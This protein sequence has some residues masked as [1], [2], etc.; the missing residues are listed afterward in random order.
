MEVAKSRRTDRRSRG[1]RRA[2]SAAVWVDAT[3]NAVT[4][5]IDFPSSTGGSFDHSAASASIDPRTVRVTTAV[6]SRVS[7]LWSRRIPA[8]RTSRPDRANRTVV[9]KM[10][11]C[12]RSNS[13]KSRIPI[14]SAAVAHSDA[15]TVTDRMRFPESIPASIQK[16][17]PAVGGPQ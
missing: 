16:V 3:A 8:G 1:L 6:A 12:V 14:A 7:R 13:L 5:A 4:V 10:R 11:P 9:P 2:A 17:G 15:T